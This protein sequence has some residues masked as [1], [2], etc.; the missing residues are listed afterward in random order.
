MDRMRTSWG[1]YEPYK[2]I[3][4]V[5]MFLLPSIIF[6][7]MIPGY[8]LILKNL[9][10]N[11]KTSQVNALSICYNDFVLRD[12]S[13]TN[14]IRF[15]GNVLLFSEYIKPIKSLMKISHTIVFK[16]TTWL[17]QYFVQIT[18][19]RRHWS[20]KPLRA[21]NFFALKC[22]KIISLLLSYL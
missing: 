14:L 15:I 18:N 20:K 6:G 13:I 16:W 10:Y 7:M 8:L 19:T 21:F 9:W 22:G 5:L 11:L 12:T 1:N 17:W 4:T 3:L 2:N